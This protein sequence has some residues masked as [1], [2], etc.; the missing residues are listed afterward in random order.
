MT[1]D[2]EFIAGATKGTLE[3]SKEQILKLVQRILNRDIAFIE[4]TETIDIVKAQRNRPEW[5]LY[6]KFVK[7]RDYRL[8]IEMGFSLKQLEN[9]LAKRE[10]LRGKIRKKY[11]DD[12]LHVSE[13]VQMGIFTRYLSLLVGRLDNPEELEDK[14][15]TVLKD[16][17]KYVLFVRTEDNIEERTTTLVNKLRILAPSALIVF[18]RGDA[19]VS[20]AS[21]IIR[22]AIPQVS[23]YNFEAQFDESTYQRYD[24]ILKKIEAI[25][26]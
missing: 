15:M 22:G 23:N 19:A 3:F 1:S 12:G 26:P 25:I 14:I 8:Q 20:N 9:N 21:N 7:D 4:D 10:D 18:S 13:L 6:R 17:D 5:E 11:G 16:I 24:F 2:E